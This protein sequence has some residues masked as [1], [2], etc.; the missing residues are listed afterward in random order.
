VGVLRDDEAGQHGLVD[1]LQ[2]V[3]RR[4]L[5]GVLPFRLLIVGQAIG[6]VDQW[7]LRRRDLPDQLVAFLAVI[8][9]TF[10]SVGMGLSPRILSPYLPC[11]Y[12]ASE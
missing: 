9:R 7:S 5:D 1:L 12:A 11:I 10:S 8:R 3:A 2:H 4:I 6:R